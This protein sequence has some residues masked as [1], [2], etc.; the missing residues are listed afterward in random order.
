M[1]KTRGLSFVGERIRKSDKEN[2]KCSVRSK[3][4]A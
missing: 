1:G 3:L 2:N 4:W